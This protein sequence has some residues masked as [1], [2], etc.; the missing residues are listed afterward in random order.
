MS[1]RHLGLFAILVS[2]R[3]CNYGI[4]P[5]ERLSERED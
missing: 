5:V 1:S 2:P 3:D 4:G